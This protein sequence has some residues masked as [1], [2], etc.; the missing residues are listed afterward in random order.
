[1]HGLQ[2]EGGLRAHRSYPNCRVSCLRPMRKGPGAA[3][4]LTVAHDMG[5]YANREARSPQG[6]EAP[7]RVQSKNTGCQRVSRAA[8]AAIDKRRNTILQR[9]E[10]AAQACKQR[11]G[12]TTTTGSNMVADPVR[13]L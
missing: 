10:R 12:A 3:W 11:P 6:P 4:A 8:R 1:M 5:S 2:G 13:G 7:A 9:R